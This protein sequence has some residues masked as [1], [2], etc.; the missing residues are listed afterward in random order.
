MFTREDT[1][2]IPDLD[3][4]DI[5]GPIES[6]NITEDIVREKL[7]EIKPG[8]SEGSDGI[9]SKVVCETLND[10]HTSKTAASANARFGLIRRHF[11]HLD[12]ESLML[13][14]KSLCRPKLEYCMAVSQ[15]RFKKDI[16]KIEKVQRRATKM[17][18]GYGE[19]SY[20]ERLKK[21]KLPSLQYNTILMKTNS[22]RETKREELEG[23]D[24]GLR[25]KQS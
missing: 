12:E 6:I 19:L 23:M 22:L 10:G 18:N 2:N 15:P 13:L 21:L 1:E 4:R 24:N 25:R 3:P 8:K 7:K 5:R 14:Y 11:Q 20:S 17:I 16:D 9:H